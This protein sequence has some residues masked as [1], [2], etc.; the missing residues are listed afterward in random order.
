MNKNAVF[1]KQ[2]EQ[3]LVS[4]IK[5]LLENSKLYTRVPSQTFSVNGRNQTQVSSAFKMFFRGRFAAAAM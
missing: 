2:V 5:G 1:L 4:K 3:I